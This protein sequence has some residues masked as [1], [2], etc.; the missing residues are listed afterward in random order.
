MTTKTDYHQLKRLVFSLKDYSE[1]I[2]GAEANQMVQ[3]A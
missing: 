1:R 3:D 2:N